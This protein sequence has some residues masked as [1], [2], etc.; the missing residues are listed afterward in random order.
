MNKIN[1]QKLCDLYNHPEKNIINYLKEYEEGNNLALPIIGS[2][3]FIMKDYE[4]AE[5]YQKLALEKGFSHVEIDLAYTYNRL[6]QYDKA[7]K[8][9][10]K[11]ADLKTPKYVIELARIYV[12]M[13]DYPNSIKYYKKAIKNN[14]NSNILG[15]LGDVYYYNRD[16][17]EAVEYYKKVVEKEESIEY[18]Y[19]L[20]SIYVDTGKYAEGVEALKK[21]ADDDYN[22]AI[23]YLGIA[24]FMLEKY[25]RAK[26]YLEKELLSGI[27][28][29][30]YYL[31]K[32]CLIKKDYTKAEKYYLE[33]VGGCTCNCYSVSS[34]KFELATL[35]YF[36][37]DF[38]KAL[39]YYDLCLKNF[40]DSKHMIELFGKKN[41]KIMYQTCLRDMSKIYASEGLK[42]KAIELCHII[43]NNYDK[44]KISKEE[45][46]KIM[47]IYF[48]TSYYDDIYNI[49]IENS[50]KFVDILDIPE[51]IYIP[52]QKNK[53]V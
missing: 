21:P 37:N 25:D 47:D 44:I 49:F 52:I 18:L 33:C 41:Y 32:I 48:G 43:C 14:T 29:A 2:T 1:K 42:D 38:S 45:F 53:T 7:V 17:N 31:G 50:K 24:Y 16:I 34:G 10:K 4:N 46:Q 28:A 39:K 5:K 23:Y 40:D 12:L 27:T 20:G 3:Y 13:S 35:Y 36:L 22:D 15:E 9:F 11:Y 51:E 8:I 6:K 26:Y 30:G 19:K